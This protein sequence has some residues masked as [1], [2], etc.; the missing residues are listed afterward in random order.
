MVGIEHIKNLKA[1]VIF[2]PNHS[3]ELD[4]VLLPLALP[5]LGR[6]S[7]LFYVAR[8]REY[9]KHPVFKWRGYLYGGFG[10][11]LLGAYPI[12][13]GKKNYALALAGHLKILGDNGSVCIFPEGSFTKTGELGIPHGG[14][15]YLSFASG[16]PV[17]P[18]YISGTYKLSLKN[19]L[20]RRVFIRI[21]FCQP[22]APQDLFVSPTAEP[23]IEEY[24][25][26]AEKIFG[27][28]REARESHVALSV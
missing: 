16:R 21:E 3:N 4:A 19:M 10:F 7:P 12:L 15:A 20:L 26:A 8:E 27:K 1:P 9:Y 6:F 5:F 14:V 17:V 2:A 24:H 25:E 18:V 13:A 11:M 28:I 22:L 23:S